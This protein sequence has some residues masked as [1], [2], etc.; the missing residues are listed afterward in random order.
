VWYLLHRWDSWRNGYLRRDIVA[1]II[2]YVPLGLTGYL[3]FRWP[4]AL[5]LPVLCGVAL[6]ATIELSQIYLPARQSSMPDL[7]CNTA[8]SVAGVLAGMVVRSLARFA[9]NR[10][11]TVHTW[12][13]WIFLAFAAGA[14]LWPFHFSTHPNRFDLIPFA[15]LIVGSGPESL[16]IIGSG[17]ALWG[18][19]VW[20]FRASG[21]R[22]RDAV[23]IV[24]TVVV[25]LQIVELFVPGARPGTTVPVLAALA[26]YVLYALNAPEKAA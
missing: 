9:P 21:N 17:F 14:S 4:R 25:A 10:R 20:L 8:G 22:L 1:N 13:A 23:S 7:I 26:G 15:R 5:F 12:Q 19:A 3:T 18:I 11:L 24:V 2:L 16:W 6:S